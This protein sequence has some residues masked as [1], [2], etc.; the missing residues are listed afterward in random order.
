MEGKSPKHPSSSSAY[1]LA[2][3]GTH[4]PEVT[5]SYTLSTVAAGAPFSE[6]SDIWAVGI[7]AIELATGDPPK[8]SETPK[9]VLLSLQ[10]DD[11][12]RLH[13]DFSRPFKDFVAACLVKEPAEVL[14][15]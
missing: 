10:K 1:W 3:E 12:P 11:P 6:K 13:G 7:L 2:P 4:I 15:T 9:S 5:D 8:S 14:P